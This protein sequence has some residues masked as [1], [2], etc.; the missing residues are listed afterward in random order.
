[1]NPVYYALIGMWV[2]IICLIIIPE[3]KRKK[4]MVARIVQRKNGK[5]KVIMKE[6]AERYIGKMCILSAFN[7]SQY[8]GVIKEVTEG[9]VLIDHNGS[10]ESV[11]L[12]FIMQI[13]EM[14]KNK[15]GEYRSFG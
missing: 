10:L 12:D 11:N 6:L 3:Q 9:G 8:V 2:V 14:P 1:M 4:L 7:S 15:K 5:E 13:K